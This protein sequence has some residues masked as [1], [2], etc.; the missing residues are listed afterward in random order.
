ME[1]N[2]IENS[3]WD[4]E[5]DDDEIESIDYEY[6]EKAVEFFSKKQKNL[7]FIMKISKKLASIF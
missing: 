4:E 6:E 2:D 3:M 1:F 5:F 7:D